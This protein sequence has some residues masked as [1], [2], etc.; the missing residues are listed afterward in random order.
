MERGLVHLYSGDGKGK[1]TCAMGLALRA[2]GRGKTV[3]VAQFLKGSDSGERA[4]LARLKEVTLLE[5]PEQ[6]KFSSA[7]DE[8]ERQEAAGRFRA[9]L[10]QAEEAAR[11]G[12]GQLV[13]LDEVCAAITA[14]LLPVEA[15]TDFLDSRPAEV[16]VVLTGRRPGPELMR[17]ADYV[18]EMRKISHPY[19][20]GVAA[21][22]GIE[23]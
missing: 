1:T 8:G 15:V 18:T 2:A 7:M 22:A 19:D 11:T 9:L 4:A 3:V 13:V 17:R 5:V 14:G 20:E 16:E 6:V 23:Y 21:R 12:R 10:T